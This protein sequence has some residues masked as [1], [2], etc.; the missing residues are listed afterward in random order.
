MS[1]KRKRTVFFRFAPTAGRAGERASVTHF[2]LLTDDHVDDA[3]PAQVQ[4][5]PDAD[6]DGGTDAQRADHVHVAQ[7]GEHGVVERPER[8]HRY[9][10]AQR[11]QEHGYQEIRVRDAV[12][13]TARSAHV[14]GYVHPVPHVVGLHFGRMPRGRSGRAK[15]VDRPGP[16]ARSHFRAKTRTGYVVVV[17][18]RASRVINL[19]VCF[20]GRFGF[21]PSPDTFLSAHVVDPAIAAAAPRQT[22]RIARELDHG[23]RN[24]VFRKGRFYAG[25][26][27]QSLF[28]G[29]G[30][31]SGQPKSGVRERKK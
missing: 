2:D 27:L 30:A 22:G 18:V 3:S 9:D 11:E 6:H 20:G 4:H 17:V 21:S 24:A 7:V 16:R 8:E 10:G 12:A 13:R 23:Q 14:L 31:H 28:K 19:S 15:P 26:D 25:A 1:W 29:V 5:V